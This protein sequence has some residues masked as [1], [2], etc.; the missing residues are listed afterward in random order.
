MNRTLLIRPHPFFDESAQ[1]YLARVAHANGHRSASTLLDVGGRP[2]PLSEL[3]RTLGT[4]DSTLQG[5]A[6]PWPKWVLDRWTGTDGCTRRCTSIHRIRFCPS[7]FK[8]QPYIRASWGLAFS[9][10]CPIH[11]VILRDSCDQCLTPITWLG[12]P[13]GRC[14]CER[15]LGDMTTEVACDWTCGVATQLLS[16]TAIAVA[17]RPEMCDSAIANLGRREL[18]TLLLALA[19]IADGRP[20]KRTGSIPGLHEVARA[21]SYVEAV[22]DLLDEWP[23]RFRAFLQRRVDEQRG[24][25]SLSRVMGSIY[26]ILYSR[27]IGDAAFDF[28]RD[29]FQVFALAAWPGRLDRRYR[30]LRISGGAKDVLTGK[31]LQEALGLSYSHVRA[32]TLSGALPSVTL[33]ST[34][35]RFF[36]YCKRNDVTAVTRHLQAFVDLRAAANT[37]GIGRGRVRALLEAKVILGTYSSG[38]WRIDRSELLALSARPALRIV[39]TAV[40]LVTVG[41]VLRYLHVDDQVCVELLRRVRAGEIRHYGPVVGNLA[42]LRVAR[43]DVELI[44]HKVAGGEDL[45]LAATVVAEVLGVKSE[46]VYQLIDAGLLMSSTVTIGGRRQRLVT[47]HAMQI[48]KANYCS[49]VEV[50]KQWGIS[51]RAALKVLRGQQLL[52]I[53]GPQSGNCR[54][55]FFNREVVACAS[56]GRMGKE[57]RSMETKK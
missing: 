51:H 18:L 15:A 6:P 8:A 43:A 49:L 3:A 46:V 40:E 28:L 52:P 2:I 4:T 24:A 30:R 56:V 16:T 48:F 27:T 10:A 54:Q 39:P 33:R 17:G 47:Q 36:T 13:F 35:G 41:H 1:S 7:C 53:V 29:E 55:Y 11:R 31:A 32:L 21:K 45:G 23:R 34:H 19:P 50:A 57:G 12:F 42:T 44:R 26:K 5:L 25:S 38:K 9:V 14:V 37:L 22:A 20:V